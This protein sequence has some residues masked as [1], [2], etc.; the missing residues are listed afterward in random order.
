[1]PSR[2]ATAHPRQTP[3][4]T[5]LSMG[6]DDVEPVARPCP[7]PVAARR[8][9]S[10]SAAQ[11]RDPQPRVTAPSEVHQ[12]RDEPVGAGGHAL[13]RPGLVFG[14]DIRRL[15][16]VAERAVAG[17]DDVLDL[18]GQERGG[19]DLG[20]GSGAED[21]RDAP[22]GGDRL[23]DERA[24]AREAIEV[25]DHEQVQAA[26]LEGDD[27]AERTDEAR[28]LADARAARGLLRR[29][30]LAHPRAGRRSRGSG[31]R[32]RPAEPEGAIPGGRR[33]PRRRTGPAAP[34]PR[35]REPTRS[36]ASAR[37]GP[38]PWR[39]AGGRPRPRRRAGG[40][41]SLSSLSSS[42]AT[43]GYCSARASARSPSRSVG[44]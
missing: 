8:A 42:G 35:S 44:S 20:G 38:R 39:G 7:G 28:L 24:H 10:R 36:G 13:V 17:H 2:V 26:R 32:Q 41:A 6:E 19:E 37:A 12:S 15:A 33:R 31:R 18:V 16:V 30:G 11:P 1:M 22:T 25:G 43:V 4:Q 40:Q 3:E 23:A 21:Q 9:S 5:P 29:S 27:G 34:R 14:H